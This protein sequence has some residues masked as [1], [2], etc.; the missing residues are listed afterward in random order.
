MYSCIYVFRYNSSYITLRGDCTRSTTTFSSIGEGRGKAGR[1]GHTCRL[2]LTTR[3]HFL[4]ARVVMALR[5]TALRGFP[6]SS[7][8]VFLPSSSAPY[9]HSLRTF[10]AVTVKLGLFS[11]GRRRSEPRSFP[12]RGFDI[13][14]KDQLIEEEELPEYKAEHFYPARL[15]EVFHDR[16]QTVAKL[17][18]GSSSTI[19]LARD[20]LFVPPVEVFKGDAIFG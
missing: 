13:V 20:L 4:I 15:G 12:S 6:R 8:S 18:Y 10:S 16:F 3:S 1:A 11:I 9:L 7:S 17:G 19:W 5:R 2:S 14:D